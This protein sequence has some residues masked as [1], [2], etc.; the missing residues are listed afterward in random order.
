MS[1]ADMLQKVSQLGQCG[2]TR[3]SHEHASTRSQQKEECYSHSA[4]FVKL[5]MRDQASLTDS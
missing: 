5:D 1:K 4:R 2:Y 3:G